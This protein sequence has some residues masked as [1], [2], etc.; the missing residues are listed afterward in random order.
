MDELEQMVSCSIQDHARNAS[1][2]QY[3]DISIPFHVRTNHKKTY[4]NTTSYSNNGL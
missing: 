2:P 4:G 1:K 3:V